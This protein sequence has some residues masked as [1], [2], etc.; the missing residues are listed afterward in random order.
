MNQIWCLQSWQC[1]K[2]LSVPTLLVQREN[3]NFSSFH[4]HKS[5][6][7]FAIKYIKSDVESLVLS[8]GC[9][10]G[11]LMLKNYDLRLWYN[12]NNFKKN[13]H[14]FPSF[15]NDLDDLNVSSNQQLISVKCDQVS[16]Y[17]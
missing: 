11:L 10:G 16:Q 6:R 15:I 13:F 4:D 14:L 7:L 17:C 3:Q 1:L 12:E 8:Y 5:F 2:S 9:K